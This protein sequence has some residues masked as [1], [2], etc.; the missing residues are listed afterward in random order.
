MSLNR[1]RIESLKC[2]EVCFRARRTLPLVA[3]YTIELL[4]ASALA[5]AQRDNKVIICHD[6]WN[7]SHT[8]KILI[9]LDAAQFVNFL[10]EV[11]KKITDCLKCLL[12][13][14]YINVWE[15]RP[16]IIKLESLGDVKNRIAYLYN[17]PVNDNLVE[18][19][20]KFPGYSSWT[21]FQSNLG[22]LDAKP[23]EY[24]PWIKLPTIRT[25]PSPVLSHTQ[26]K[27]L[28]KLL[29]A[30]NKDN[31]HKLERQPN[32][33]MRYFGVS[34]D[35]EVLEVNQAII[36]NI[37]ANEE[38][39]AKE[40]ERKGWRVMGVAKLCSQPILKPHTPKKLKRR[41]YV[42]SFVKE[43]RIEA[44]LSFKRFCREC[45]ECYKRWK[46]GDFRVKWPPGA[47]KPP[48]PP[49]MNIIP[50]YQ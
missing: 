40:R 24:V 20:D 32:A 7:G 19:I 8:H 28:T 16:L 15:G 38:K 26:D 31:L 50:C 30:R 48:L 3:Y 9:A 18:T 17:N 41:I 10:G 36:R 22:K 14:D 46:A 43:L 21:K 47:F 11:Q 1:R 27:N 35:E 37:R 45:R 4:I 49:G 34:K 44:I 13:I 5:R 42:I 25:I 23:T 2:Y 33:W 29:R 39:M 12:G 6:I